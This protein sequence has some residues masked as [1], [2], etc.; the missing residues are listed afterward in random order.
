MGWHVVV[1]GIRIDMAQQRQW[2][3]R[4]KEGG[5]QMKRTFWL[6]TAM[7]LLLAAGCDTK[8]TDLNRGNA[9]FEKGQYDQAISAYNKALEINPRFALA[10]Y[11]R[12]L[13][14]A[15]MGQY[16]QAISNYNKALELNPKYAGAYN[17]RGNAYAIKDQYDQAISNFNKALEINP[18]LAFAYHNRGAAYF[19]KG[20]YDKAWGDVHKAQDL[21]STIHPVFLKALREASG[22]Q[23]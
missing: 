18:G 15:R 13:A 10:Y 7:V 22:R 23:K 17:N 14:Y 6:L 2:Q 3:L 8:Q 12:G 16:D 4:G 21:G 11:S 9:Y 1:V 5:K 20:Q 19:E